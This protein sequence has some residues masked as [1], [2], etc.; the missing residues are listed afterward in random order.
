MT[1]KIEI[2]SIMLTYFNTINKEIMISLPQLV[3]KTGISRATLKNFLNDLCQKQKD[4][5]AIIPIKTGKFQF[6]KIERK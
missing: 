6:F 5:P 4:F 2:N 3:K 1:T